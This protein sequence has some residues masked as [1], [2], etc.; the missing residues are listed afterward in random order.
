MKNTDERLFILGIISAHQAHGYQI[1][2]ALNA[3]W[4][5]I[6]IDKAKVYRI[7]NALEKDGYLNSVTEKK[8]NYPPRQ[9]Y[10]ITEI[11]KTEFIK[12][13]K[14]RLTTRAA[15]HLPDAVSLNF[16]GMLPPAEQVDL[17]KQRLQKAIEKLKELDSIDLET[18]KNHL[19]IDYL[20]SQLEFE[21]NWL[22]QLTKTKE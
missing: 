18:R 20:F 17:L 4:M 14:E 5:P 8:E 11:G 15:T 21:I 6:K 12:T 13:L 7:L 10:S 22:K 19:G 2:E 3:P 9:V 16:L 1:T